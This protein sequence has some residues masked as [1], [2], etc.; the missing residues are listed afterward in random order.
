MQQRFPMKLNQRHW[1]RQ[2]RSKNPDMNEMKNKIR[3][4]VC[5][6]LI[7]VLF[8]HCTAAADQ[9]TGIQCRFSDSLGSKEVLFD[10]YEQTAEITTV[11]TNY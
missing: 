5:C 7:A 3:I 1:K 10:I 6:I 2:N 8:I 9:H 4:T 11:S